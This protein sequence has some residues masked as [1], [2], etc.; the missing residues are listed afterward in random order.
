MPSASSIAVILTV[1]CRPQNLP[2]QVEAVCRQSVGPAAVWAWANEPTPEVSSALAA[3]SLDRVV[4][5]SE[6]TFFHGRFAGGLR[7][8][9]KPTLVSVAVRWHSRLVV[10]A[11]IGRA[12]RHCL[13]LPASGAVDGRQS[14]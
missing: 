12:K 8:A 5:S 13:D 9:C 6:N 1:Y 10:S 11:R 3:A 7:H 14:D 2:R 4:T